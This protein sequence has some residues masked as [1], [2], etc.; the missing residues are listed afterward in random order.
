MN[1]QFPH[2]LQL[3]LGITIMSSSGALGRFI[4]LPVPF[5]IL[6]RCIIASLAL[7]VL[8]KI[9]KIEMKLQYG[10]S[11][12]GIV[13][14]SAFLGA[15][16]IT[17]FISLKLSSVAVGMLSLFTYPVITTFLEPLILKT[18]FQKSS[19]V[20]GIIGFAGLIFLV[21]ELNLENDHTLGVVMGICSAVFYSLRNILSKKQV[22]EQS[23]IA[24]MFYQ[25]LIISVL[26]SPILL[27]SE[28]DFTVSISNNWIPFMILGLTTTAAGHTLFV[29]SFR[30]FSISTVS[31]ISALTPL[32]G[33]FIG[34]LVLSE[35]PSGRTYIGGLLILATVIIESVRSIK[36]QNKSYSTTSK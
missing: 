11:F 17:Y 36:N 9:M 14:T 20:L 27:W 1:R 35:V 15:H 13:V 21:P 3:G 25:L 22:S 24:L 33:T 31:I 12:W 26:L 23:G 34:F 7:F 18:H 28:L 8:I 5:I 2:F 19:L 30:H 16:W 4:D 29:L 32:M 6:V 10:K